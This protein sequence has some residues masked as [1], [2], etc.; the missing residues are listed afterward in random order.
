MPALRTCIE[1]IVHEIGGARDDIAG[2]GVPAS[3]LRGF[4]TPYL[5]DKPEVRHRSDTPLARAKASNS[6]RSDRTRRPR[7]TT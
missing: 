7:S 3:A 4:R 5:S 1:K 2:C 6:S